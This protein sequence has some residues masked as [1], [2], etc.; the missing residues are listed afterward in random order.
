MIAQTLAA[1]WLCARQT[2]LFGVNVYPLMFGMKPICG[3]PT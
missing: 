2:P 1:F 3:S